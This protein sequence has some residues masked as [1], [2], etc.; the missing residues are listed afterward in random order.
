MSYNAPRGLARSERFSGSATVQ[1]VV[2]VFVGVVLA[3]ASGQALN[4]YQFWSALVGSAALIY[5]LMFYFRKQWFTPIEHTEV[6]SSDQ[7]LLSSSITSSKRS[8]YAIS[9]N[10]L[11]LWRSSTFSYY[12]HLD[13]VMSL[14]AYSL[15]VWSPVERLST[16]SVDQENFFE[17]G[18]ELVSAIGRGEPPLIKHRLRL[19]IYPEWTYDSNKN[20]VLQ[21]IRSHSAARIPCIPIVADKLV[22]ILNTSE[23]NSINELVARL[24]QTVVD[25]VPT[26]SRVDY[27]SIRRTIA[28]GRPV[29]WP[30]VLPDILL[31]DSLSDFNTSAAWWY[32]ANGHVNRWS[33][34]SRTDEPEVANANAVFQ[35]IC[36]HAREAAWSNYAPEMIGGVAMAIASE[37]LGS[38]AF[39][40]RTYYSRWLTWIEDHAKVNPSASLLHDWLVREKAA[41]E[42]FVTEYAKTHPDRASELRI[43][44]LGCGFGR[45]IIQLLAQHPDITAVGIDINAS[46][47]NEATWEAKRR[48]LSNRAVFLLDD[49]SKLAS[50]EPR[51]F[52]LAICMTNTIG[53]LPDKKQLELVR[54]VETVLRPGGQLLVSA[55]SHGSVKAQ[56]S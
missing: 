43:L 28:K 8:S 17:E 31:I 12:L 3:L 44:D 22:A 10:W 48:G 29:G 46:M 18:W 4:T 56:G 15:G 51:E 49:M 9:S 25:K 7:A 14:M 37:T 11:G 47:I 24:G 53:N 36:R 34:D 33:K 52:D 30:L 20:D 13:A 35:T 5:L 40:G 27:W 41:L 54:R 26:L 23:R 32:S 45:H 55:Y 21:L 6:V 38:E 19:L 2:A 50:C 42:V 1:V 39:F 16:D